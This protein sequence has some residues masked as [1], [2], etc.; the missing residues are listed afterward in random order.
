MT[1]Y[2]KNYI[3]KGKADQKFDNLVKVTLKVEALEKFIYEKEGQKYLTFEISKLKEAD[4][5]G[6]THTCFVTTKASES[7]EPSQA[8][9][10]SRTYPK[11]AAG[12]SKSGK[13]KSL[14]KKAK[15]ATA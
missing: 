9:E 7:Q 4:E 10:T 15:S 3:G 5:Y 14:P 1:T 2:K 13:Q 6:R 8:E 11:T 12:N